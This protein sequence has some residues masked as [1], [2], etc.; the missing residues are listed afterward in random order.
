[1]LAGDEINEGLLQPG[2][3][4]GWIAEDRARRECYLELRDASF[5]QS[6]VPFVH[7]ALRGALLADGFEEVL[8][9]A[10]ALL[11]LVREGNPVATAARTW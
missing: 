10:R 9:V 7:V 8:H 4:P 6:H 2:E 5:L 11:Q 1:M 3:G